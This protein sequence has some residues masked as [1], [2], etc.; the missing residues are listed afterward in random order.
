MTRR[1]RNDCFGVDSPRV[2]LPSEGR[3]LWQWYSD[4]ATTRRVDDGLPQLLTPLEWQAWSE[5][6][7]E[8]VRR[9]EFSVLMEM[10]RAFIFAYR[11]EISD[12]RQRDAGNKRG[13]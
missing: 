10:D 11:K 7:G 2:G 13:R 3:Y 5:I 1:D 9:E 6:R 12:Q 8:I 4:A